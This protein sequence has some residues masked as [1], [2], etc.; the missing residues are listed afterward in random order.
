MLAQGNVSRKW[1]TVQV[2]KFFGAREN[3]FCFWQS[4][5]MPSRLRLATERAA[6]VLEESHRRIRT[7]S[8]TSLT[9]GG[10]AQNLSAATAEHD[11][12]GVREDRGDGEAAR[13]LHVHEERVGVL[14][15]TLELVA[16]RLL[17]R[18]RVHEINGKRL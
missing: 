2:A 4:S 11:R 12:L 16:A 18:N 10:L 15:Q 3:V 8:K 14:N 9:T 13:A 6:W 1:V 17:L 7:N 5:W